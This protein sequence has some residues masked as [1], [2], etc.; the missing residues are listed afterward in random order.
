[1]AP[2]GYINGST[3]SVSNNL[4]GSYTPAQSI[5]ANSATQIVVEELESVVE[6]MYTML[7]RVEEK[8][9]SCLTPDMEVKNTS[10]ENS[11]PAISEHSPLVGKL[12]VISNNLRTALTRMELLMDRVEL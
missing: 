8:L 12:A 10:Q 6:R 7:K 9:E 5:G 3:M 11:K 1:M 2:N 4:D